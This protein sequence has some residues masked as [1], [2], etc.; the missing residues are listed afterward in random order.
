MNTP[1]IIA[2]L[3]P[4]CGWSQG[5]FAHDSTD[6]LAPATSRF[7]VSNNLW[8]IHNLPA[9][10][11]HRREEEERESFKCYQS[12][13]GRFGSVGFALGLLGSICSSPFWVSNSCCACSGVI[14]P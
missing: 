12:F 3:K 6:A 9:S 14:W 10:T 1:K 13:T 2:Y 4:T 7:Q 5:V 11:C 8:C